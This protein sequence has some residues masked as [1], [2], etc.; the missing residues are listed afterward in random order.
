MD[1]EDRIVNAILDEVYDRVENRDLSM[2]DLAY[3]ALTLLR[4]KEY[5]KDDI[6]RAD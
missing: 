1:K 2:E 3:A 4:I 5:R 6:I